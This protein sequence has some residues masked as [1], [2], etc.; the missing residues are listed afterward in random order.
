VNEGSIE[1]SS[2]KHVGA[3]VGRLEAANLD[4]TRSVREVGLEDFFARNRVRVQPNDF[5][6][7]QEEPDEDIEDLHGIDFQFALELFLY[8]PRLLDGP[9]TVT[10]EVQLAPAARQLRGGREANEL[11]VLPRTQ[12]A[13]LFAPIA[14][15][16]KSSTNDLSLEIFE[17]DISV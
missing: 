16:F 3:H 6:A 10:I 14:S 15:I 5:L 2:F 17:I 13:S 7:V 9:N 12:R 4:V 11:V 1:E 8:F